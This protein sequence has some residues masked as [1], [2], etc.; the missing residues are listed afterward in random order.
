MDVVVMMSVECCLLNDV[1]SRFRDTLV[2]QSRCIQA[3]HQTVPDSHY[4]AGD[5]H[6]LGVTRGI[7]IG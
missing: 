2:A 7:Q 5:S 6:A 3:M 1:I 4:L